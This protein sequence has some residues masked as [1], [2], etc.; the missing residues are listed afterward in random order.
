MF[1][2]CCSILSCGQISFGFTQWCQ[3]PL[4]EC[5]RQPS[6]ISKYFLHHSSLPRWRLHLSKNKIHHNTQTIINLIQ[7]W[8]Y[9]KILLIISTYPVQ[10][11]SSHV[12]DPRRIAMT[13][14]TMY[15]HYGF[16]GGFEVYPFE[17]KLFTWIH[18]KI[19]CSLLSTDGKPRRNMSSA[20]V[21]RFTC[22]LKFLSR[23]D[24]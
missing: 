2:N 15:N 17:T 23:E 4:A 9:R 7:A 1:N 6:S 14:K 12:P 11:R 5:L 21:G 3:S 22:T 8:N 20:S 18:L 16:P 10:Q 13:H 19:T 24:M